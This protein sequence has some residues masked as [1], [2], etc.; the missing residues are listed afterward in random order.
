MN[1]QVEHEFHKASELLQEES[2]LANESV[3]PSRLSKPK[4]YL[5]ENRLL[6]FLLKLMEK[7]P[8][9]LVILFFLKCLV[10]EVLRIIITI[11]F[12]KSDQRV[13][14]ANTSKLLC[15]THFIGA[16]KDEFKELYFGKLF[17]NY[18]EN[19]VSYFFI[20]QTEIRES[21]VTQY[22]NRSFQSDFKV[23]GKS[24]SINVTIGLIMRQL[25]GT[26]KLL[27][28]Y[29]LES[30]GAIE[31]KDRIYFAI[32]NQFSRATLN[33]LLLTSSILKYIK[34]SSVEKIVITFEGNAYESCLYEAIS[35]RNPEIEMIFY[36]HAPVT[37]DHIGIR[38]QLTRNLSNAIVGVSGDI[39]KK[40]FQD[41]FAIS[42]QQKMIILGSTK[43]RFSKT[44]LPSV[45]KKVCLFAPEG[46]VCAVEEMLFVALKL[47]AVMEDFHFIFRVHPVLKDHLETLV[48]LYNGKYLNFEISTQTIEV[49]FARSGSCIYRGSSVAI[50]GAA[51]GVVPIFYSKDGKTSVDP[52]SFRNRG[53]MQTS[54]IDQIISILK[55]L[56][57]LNP[58][59]WSELATN[60]KSYSR[61][62]FSPLKPL[63]R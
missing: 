26:I 31:S 9:S 10:I 54:E 28:T 14:I 57:T 53:Q 25:R 36:Q 63:Q 19:E 16:P 33:N 44:P 6:N 17:D 55:R 18:N 45:F 8:T 2:Y 5:S 46:T 49:D 7:I 40:M 24:F 48:D 27:R 41:E 3:N 15:I 60:L 42:S 21:E 11:P 20:N 51:F 35:R 50:E 61:D 23:G 56:E 22:L 1:S 62:Y 32:R 38:N 47:S 4:L 58:S 34:T 52:I 59:S 29:N 13:K 39:T 43:F 30:W 37:R 12:T